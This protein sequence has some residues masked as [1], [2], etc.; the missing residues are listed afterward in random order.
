MFSF[1]LI[2]L[3][4][5]S[6]GL[7]YK[8]ESIFALNNP[9]TMNEG[10]PNSN[11]MKSGLCWSNNLSIRNQVLF[12]AARSEFHAHTPCCT[13][14][15]IKTGYST[16]VTNWHPKKHQKATLTLNGLFI[17]SVFLDN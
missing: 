6:K 10:W 2:F 5:V 12:I 4:L 15:A 17:D 7:E 8:T 1:N 9:A 13:D 11:P 14:D 3:F 16:S